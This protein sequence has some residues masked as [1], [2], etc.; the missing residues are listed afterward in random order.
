MSA[1]PAIDRFLTPF[2]RPAAPVPNERGVPA[3]VREYLAAARSHL[4]HLHR[5]GA[6]GS[7]VNETNAT[8][9]GISVAESYPNPSSVYAPVNIPVTVPPG[10]LTDV[11][12]EILDS[13]SRR[14]RRLEVG[15]M[16]A[17]TQDIVWDGKND[18]GR[19]CAPGVYRGWVI[20]G[21]ERQSIRLVR[22]P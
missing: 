3:A 14:V 4:V 1:P 8:T 6:P 21:S 15:A 13:G 11:S 2:S 16:S 9:A 19:V 5:S 10:G 17:G 22:V 20:S 12:V 7:R 18:S